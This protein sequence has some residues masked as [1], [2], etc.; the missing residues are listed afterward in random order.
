MAS[1][2]KTPNYQ[3]SQ[4]IATDK[5]AW[6]TDVNG[7]MSKIDTAIKGVADRVGVNETAITEAEA[8]IEDNATSISALQASSAQHG[9]DITDL[10]AQDIINKNDVTNLSTRVTALEYDY[11]IEEGASGVW[12]YRKWKSG[13]AEIWG[14]SLSNI[15]LSVSQWGGVYGCDIPGLGAYPVTLTS[16]DFIAGNVSVYGKNGWSGLKWS[17]TSS[18]YNINNAP[19]YMWERGTSVSGGDTPVLRTLYVKGRYN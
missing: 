15:S 8:N 3:L 14:K 13:I 1:T 4:F 12:T 5:P 17:G 11:I 19:D 16:L 10:K 2:N 6:L 9:S 18:T 7:D